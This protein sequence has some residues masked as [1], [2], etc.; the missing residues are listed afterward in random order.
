MTAIT[1]A[2]E[3]KRARLNED[4]KGFTLIEL[5]V[6]VLIIGILTAIAVPIFLGQ[7]EQAR[8]AAAKSDLGVAKVAYVSA[9]TANN[10]V[11]D[12]AA[13]GTFGY[14]KSPDVD[15]IAIGAGASKTTFCMSTKVTGADA[16]RT[17]KITEST[18]VALGTCP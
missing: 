9:V 18:A 3:A 12:V 14:I 11:P 7:Q 13:L 10:A 16:A 17:Y 5:L 2:L 6:V 8:E 1:R 4:E 15:A